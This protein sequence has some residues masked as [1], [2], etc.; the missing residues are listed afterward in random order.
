MSPTH[1]NRMKTPKPGAKAALIEKIEA[2]IVRTGMA[3]IMTAQEVP[4][5]TIPM[6]YSIGLGDLGFPEVIVFGLPYEVA[7]T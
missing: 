3:I 4:E 6:V 1:E 5:G 2:D 7:Q